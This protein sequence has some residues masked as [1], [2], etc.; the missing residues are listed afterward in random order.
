MKLLEH[1]KEL[2]LH[3]NNTEELKGLILQLAVQGK[4]T[5]NWRKAN[6]DAEPATHLLEKIEAE[7]NKL[8]KEKKLKKNKKLD[9]IQESEKYFILPDSWSWERLGNIGN[10]FNGDSVNKSVKKAKYTGLENGYPYIA[11]KDVGYGFEKIDHHNGVR[12][13]FNEPKFKV[14]RK[15]TALICSEG[16]SAGKKMGLL[17]E[18]C[19]FGNK[20][21]AL[22]QYGGIESLYILSFYGASSFGKAFQ[23]KMTGII[24]GI[25]KNNF[26]SLL[27]PIPPLEEQK[28][29]VEVVKQLLTEV[30]QLESLTKERIQLKES[31][32]VSALN[33][34]TE[35]ENTQEEWNFLQQHF[36]S[37]FTEKKNIKSLRETILQEAVQGK[38]TAKWR[39]D[40]PNI[41]PASELLERIEAEKQQLI[42]EKKIKKEK[43]IPAIEDEDILDDLPNGWVWCRMGQ[44]GN[45]MS[46]AFVD[47]P[48]G[49]SINTKSDY[50][51]SGVPVLRMVNVKPYLFKD[52][53]MK[54]ISE[55]KYQTF[56]R[57]GVLP[58]DILFSKVGAGI[59]EACIVPD[60]FEYGM[61][62]T[63]GISRIR[64]GEIVSNDYLC[65]F[66]NGHISHFKSLSQN[67]AQPFLNMT[68]IKSVPFPLA[69]LKEQQV[70]VEKVNS[71]MALCDELEQQIDNSQTQIE[72]LMQSC[73]KEVFEHESN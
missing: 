14:A 31:F 67:S 38:L 36:S 50:I 68:Q 33:R 40:N 49:S 37:F 52:D 47:G 27:I 12:I 44:V 51:E 8:I 34:L 28:A 43:K 24:G 71:L 58:G 17:E 35:A 63:T 10:I 18:D 66:I 39:E 61:L 26:S 22:E 1:F 21:Y 5:V 2:S 55:Q 72:Q 42:A 64:V 45:A 62:S 54:Y 25:S 30:E 53:S 57:H 69:P 6:P 32:V 23:T 73:L 13:P 65:H 19:C 70:I 48:F 4:L 59:G 9:E 56:L 29:I 15:G 11:T 41:E 20:L 60:T 7:K 16:G 46:S 3:P